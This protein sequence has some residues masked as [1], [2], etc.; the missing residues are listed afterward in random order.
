MNYNNNPPPQQPQ[1]NG[2]KPTNGMAITGLIFGILSIVSC[3]GS[4]INEAL[5]FA[6]PILGIIFSSI[7]ISKANKIGQAKEWL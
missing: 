7:G 2:Y 4:F 6:M 1:Y 5:G 3:G